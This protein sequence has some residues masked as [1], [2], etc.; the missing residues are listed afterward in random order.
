MTKGMVGMKDL[1]EPMSDY[2]E[3][4]DGAL[5]Y[6][7]ESPRQGLGPV[8]ASSAVFASFVLGALVGVGVMVLLRQLDD[9]RDG[10][11]ILRRI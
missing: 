11:V 4:W 8:A 5:I 1:Y 9:A 2:A 7:K 6:G 10:E 3:S